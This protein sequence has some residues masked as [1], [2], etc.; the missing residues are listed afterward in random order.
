[1]AQTWFVTI[2]K[3][4]LWPHKKKIAESNEQA[5]KGFNSG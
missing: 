5:T 2:A 4:Q 1:M 3:K